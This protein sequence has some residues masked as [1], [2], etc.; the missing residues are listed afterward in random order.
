[1]RHRWRRFQLGHAQKVRGH[2][3]R[4][5]N[6]EMQTRHLRAL[7]KR[8]HAH[9]INEGDARTHAPGRAG[10]ERSES[11]LGWAATRQTRRTKMSHARRGTPSRSIGCTE[12][13]NHE[14][15]KIACRIQNTP[16]GQHG[17]HGRCEWEGSHRAGVGAGS[18]RVGHD[19]R[20][21][22]WADLV[23]AAGAKWRCT[24]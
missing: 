16:S 22:P 9:T 19:G 23:V 21:T 4:G 3:G 2:R 11:P 12:V 6:R 8:G 17:R 5:R 1:M 15:S 14:R 7:W 13:C 24:R 10:Q 20:R 18:R